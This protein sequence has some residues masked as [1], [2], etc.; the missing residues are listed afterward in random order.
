SAIEPLA[1]GEMPP[2]SLAQQRLWFLAQMDEAA[3]AAY[4]IAGGFRLCGKLDVAALRQALDRIVARHA[5]LRTHIDSREGAPV[6]VVEPAGCGFP[7]RLCD[8][9]GV[10]TPAPF[11][12]VFDLTRGPLAQGELVRISDDEHWLRLALH[13]VIADGWS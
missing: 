9:T 6:Q 2:L 8:A 5:A 1:A 10:G 7:L 4:V 3:G 11:A 13:H 12:P